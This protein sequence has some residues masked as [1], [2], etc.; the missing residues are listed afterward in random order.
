MNQDQE[1]SFSNQRAL[2]IDLLAS[3]ADR[4]AGIL[5]CPGFS[6][7][8]RSA[9]SEAIRIAWERGLAVPTAGWV[10]GLGQNNGNRIHHIRLTRAGWRAVCRRFPVYLPRFRRLFPAPRSHR[11]T[12]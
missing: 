7:S 11:K 8:S 5:S 12:A 3:M 10:P 9:L 4:P 6:F 2:C 1:L